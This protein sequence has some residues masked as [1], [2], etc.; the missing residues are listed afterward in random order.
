LFVLADPRIAEFI[1]KALAVGIP[2]DSLVEVLSAQGWPE[3]EIYNALADHYRWRPESIFRA[4][5]APELQPER[6]IER[7]S[8]SNRR[9]ERFSTPGARCWNA[10]GREMLTVLAEQLS[11][12]PNSISIEGHT[13]SLPY[14]NDT[15]YGN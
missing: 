10:N 2:H 5:P 13:D 4:G 15:G 1:E 14:A 3:K 11:S 6:R 9:T 12:V 7:S 8:C